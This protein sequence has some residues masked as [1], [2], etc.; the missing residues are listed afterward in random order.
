[1]PF[2]DANR[3]RVAYQE[4]SVIGTPETTNMQVLR[5]TSSNMAANKETAV[6]D[7]LRS[8]RMVSDLVETQFTSGGDINFELSLTTFED[9]LEALLGG[10][11]STAI[12]ETNEA[13]TITLTNTLQDTGAT[14]AFTNVSVGQWLLLS[15]FSNAE[16]N[17][18]VRVA[19]VVDVDNITVDNVLTNEVAASGIG[20]KGKM[21]RNGTTQRAFT[22][23]QYF[24]DTDDAFRFDS[25]EVGAMSMSL[26]AGAIVTGSFTLGGRATNA[27]ATT[28]AAATTAAT[29]T[30]V[31]NATS[32]VANV[33]EDGAITSAAIMQLDFTVDNGLR[34]QFTIG[35][36]YPT[37]IAVGRQNVSGTF[38]VY[39]EDLELYTKMLN[40]TATSLSLDVSDAAGNSMRISFP[41]IKLGSATPTP[42]GIDQDIMLDAEFQAIAFTDTASTPQ[43]YQIQIDIA[44]A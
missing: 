16:N 2:A 19:T 11:Y 17:T 31:V 32:N 39:F 15:G 12:A 26:A 28:Y 36:K 42:E 14:G 18:W 30:D 9:F 5:I 41:K 20:I 3:A 22:V 29:T 8:D 23:E 38:Q 6:S 44:A 24:S 1:M 10:T 33:W 21:L 40:H 43:T 25:C 27:K 35:S 4:E 7:E 13:I 37:S 34:N